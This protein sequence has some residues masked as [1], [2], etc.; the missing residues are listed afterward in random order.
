MYITMMS[1]SYKLE[2]GLNLNVAYGLLNSNLN[3][4]FTTCKLTN[5]ADTTDP[6]KLTCFPARKNY[7]AKMN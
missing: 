7:K 2:S 1:T 6:G 5:P 3:G 4:E